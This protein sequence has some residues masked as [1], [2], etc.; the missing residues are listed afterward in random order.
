ME[1]HSIGFKPEMI[2]S[3]TRLLWACQVQL[4]EVSHLMGASRISVICED[5]GW[6]ATSFHPTAS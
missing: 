3:K 2:E 1:K 6:I 5:R 4:K